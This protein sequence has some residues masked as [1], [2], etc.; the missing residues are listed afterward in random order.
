MQLERSSA[1]TKS[2][3]AGVLRCT[4]IAMLHGV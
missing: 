4:M 3:L 2:I 1:T